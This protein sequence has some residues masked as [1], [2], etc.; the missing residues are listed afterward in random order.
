MRFSPEAGRGRASLS[1]GHWHKC[2]LRKEKSPLCSP[3][4]SQDQNSQQ[5][6]PRPDL[7]FTSSKKVNNLHSKNSFL[8]QR[9]WVEKPSLS[10]RSLML[11]VLIKEQ[12]C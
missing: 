8:L 2:P 12:I 11:G 6:N 3:R 10:F 5:Q 7:E 1:K 9:L 4:V